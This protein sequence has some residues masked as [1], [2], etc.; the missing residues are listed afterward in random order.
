MKRADGFG[1]SLY[2]DYDA[3][4]RR[5]SL[6]R[7][8]GVRTGYTYDDASQLLSMVHAQGASVVLGFGYEYDGHGMRVTRTRDDGTRES[9]GYDTADR[10][11]QVDYGAKLACD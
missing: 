4:G 10:L 5:T 8:N 9:Y 2:F 6:L 1:G 11:T 3:A 7:P